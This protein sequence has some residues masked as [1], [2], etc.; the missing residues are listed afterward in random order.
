MVDNVALDFR[1]EGP[2]FDDLRKL[3][4]AV[5]GVGTVHKQ[6][7]DA[8]QAD[9]KDSTQQT[10]QFSRVM[11]DASKVVVGLGKA[12]A[13]EAMAKQLQ[14]VTV[15][16]QSKKRDGLIH[17]QVCGSI[18]GMANVYEIPLAQIK[19]AESFGF[20]KWSFE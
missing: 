10:Q 7:Q 16:S 5:K 9:V 8:I 14:G 19:K 17:I 18:T 20:K 6:V 13:L 12:V 3:G 4:D 1:I 15:F 11:T 2:I